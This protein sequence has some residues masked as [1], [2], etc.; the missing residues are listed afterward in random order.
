[1]PSLGG[2][3]ITKTQWT[4]PTAIRVDFVSSY[5]ATRLYQL[6]AG[7]TRIGVTLD[8]LSRSVTGQLQP[9]LWPQQL[10]LV[11]VAPEDR[12]TDYG[13]SL[14]LRPYNRVKMRFSTSGWAADSRYVE[15][16]AGTEPGGAP[17]EDNLIDRLIF[18]TNRTYEITSPPMPGSGEWNF[19]V[20]GRD[21]RPPDGNVGTALSVA[22]EVLAHPPDVALRQGNRFAVS[23]EGGVA[24]VSWSL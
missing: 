15:A 13:P 23:I 22:R 9:S 18:D 6:Y 20:R 11:A 12:F 10:Q 4:G 21:S 24:T 7:R 2:H 17:D 19:E 14:P 8:P 16:I 3:Q 5:A 1:M